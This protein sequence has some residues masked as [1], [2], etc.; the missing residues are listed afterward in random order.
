MNYALKTLMKLK[1]IH[2]ELD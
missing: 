2:P 1:K